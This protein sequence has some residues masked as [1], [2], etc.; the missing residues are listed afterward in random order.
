MRGVQD[1]IGEKAVK[2]V[3][4]KPFTQGNDSIFLQMIGCSGSG[5]SD[6][7]IVGQASAEHRFGRSSYMAECSAVP[8]HMFI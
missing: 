6:V 8:G 2:S 3:D 4:A 7:G 5:D 1:D